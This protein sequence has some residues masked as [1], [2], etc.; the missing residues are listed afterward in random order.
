M[1]EKPAI[2]GVDCHA[3]IMAVDL[4]LAPDIHSR[5]ARDVSAEE[6]LAVLGSHGIS[7]G[8]LT[9][10]SFYGSNN[11]LLL[12]A[13]RRYPHQLRGTVIVD[14]SS[15]RLEQQMPCHK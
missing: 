14:P 15:P 7:H 13:L 8:V 9:A 3:H 2:T 12:D 5:P 6:Y 11:I 10:P 4:P 1:S